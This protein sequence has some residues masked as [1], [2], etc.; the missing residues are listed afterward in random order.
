MAAD[1]LEGDVFI[2]NSDLVYTAQMLRDMHAV[3][4]DCVLAL[5]PSRRYTANVGTLLSGNLVLD[6]G[7]HIPTTRAAAVFS[8]AAFVR[9]RVIDEFKD[10]T[11]RCDPYLA[12]IGWSMV[13]AAMIRKG[14]RVGACIHGGPVF[15]VNS[16]STY[17]SAKAYV[18]AENPA[19]TLRT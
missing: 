4:E 3:N 7:R 18:A 13:F 16:V 19:A 14:Y 12:G 15:D 17:A 2:L 9:A 5:H 11:L 6:V 10:V 1:S 8:G